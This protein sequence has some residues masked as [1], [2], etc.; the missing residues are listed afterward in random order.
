MENEFSRLVNALSGLVWSAHPDGSADF[1]NQH[2]LDYV[3]SLQRQ[4]H[5][6]GWTVACI[7]TI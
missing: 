5:G 3:G 6:S 2:Y 7:R 4:A 1:F